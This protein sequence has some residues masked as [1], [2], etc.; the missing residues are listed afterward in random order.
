MREMDPGR[1]KILVDTI[2]SAAIGAAG[3]PALLE[4]F[5]REFDHAYISLHGHDLTT[6]NNIGILGSGYSE[7][8]LASFR[9]HY[10]QLN[11]WSARAAS[12]PIGVA[13]TSES[14]LPTEHLRRTEWYN[15]W[16]RPQEDIGT[17]VG[18]TLMRDRRRIFRISCN[19]RLADRDRLQPRI[20][21]TLNATAP[22]L[23]RAFAIYHNARTRSE[24]RAEA[25]DMFAGAAFLVGVDRRIHFFNALARGMMSGPAGALA[26]REGRLG[27]VDQRA[28]GWLE[29]VLRQF[30]SRQLSAAGRALS[31]HAANGDASHAFR[32]LP[33]PPMIGAVGRAD[34]FDPGHALALVLIS[35]QGDRLAGNPLSRREADVLARLAQGMANDRIAFALGIK[36]ETVNLH[37]MSARRRLGAR[38]REEAIAIAVRRNLI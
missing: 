8:Y 18:I 20:V 9:Q 30:A 37:I 3:W 7:P 36:P 35:P 24:S 4:Q 23:R 5:Q 27:F 25:L 31:L 12:A 1:L 16:V 14:L 13:L 15:D 22:H 6:R 2:Y 17:G 26:C 34:Y 33:A 38:T 11:P 29:R 32:V 10:A 21:D 19:I 28:Q